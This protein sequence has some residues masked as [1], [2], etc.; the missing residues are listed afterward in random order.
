VTRVQDPRFAGRDSEQR[1]P[2][3]V[4]KRPCLVRGC[5]RYAEGGASY[6]S[7]HEPK[8]RSPSSVVTRTSAEYRRARKRLLAEPRPW[9]CC[10]CGRVIEREAD[11]A[12][13]HI[14]PVSKGGAEGD[15]WPAHRW[16]NRKRG[17]ADL[18]Q[19]ERQ[20]RADERA[21]RLARRTGRVF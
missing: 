13:D 2:A 6:C 11:L 18:A 15:V 3:S 17:D 10:L 16:C 14:T 12:A 7:E 4:A 21:E 8:R 5:Q 1:V 20:R 19:S 9:V